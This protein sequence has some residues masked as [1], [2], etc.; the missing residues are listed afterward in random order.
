MG[1]HV[2]G[3]VTVLCPEKRKISV[4]RRCALLCGEHSSWRLPA[5]VQVLSRQTRGPQ[6]SEVSS[7]FRVCGE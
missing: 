1:A 5:P 7:I 6:I 2:G 4:E 3:G